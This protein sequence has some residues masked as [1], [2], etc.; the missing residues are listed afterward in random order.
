MN[1]AIRKMIISLLVLTGIIHSQSIRT[2]VDDSLALLALYNSTD[3]DNWNPPVNWMTAT[4]INWDG[5]YIEDNRVIGIGL[6]NRNLNGIIT[7]TLAILDSLKYLSLYDNPNLSGTLPPFLGSLSALIQLGIYN[8]GIGG[9]IPAEYGQLTSLRY[10]NLSNNQLSGTIPD[11]F[12]TIESL[13][14]L[15]LFDNQLSGSIPGTVSNLKNVKNLSLQGNQLS[16]IIPDN[17]TGLDSLQEL[18]L[19]DNQ[20]SGSIPNSICNLPR[21]QTLALWNNQLIGE[22]PADIGLLTNLVDLNIQNNKLT[23]AIP[24]SIGNLQNL[25]FLN[26]SANQL[27]GNLPVEFWNLSKLKHCVLCVNQLTGT[28]PEQIGNMD[29][30]QYLDLGD[31]SFSGALPAA[32]TTLSKLQSVWIGNNDLSGSLP[33]NIGDL[34]DLEELALYGNTIS[35]SIP[36]SILSCSKLRVLFLFNNQLD[37]SIPADIGS[38]VMLE[39]VALHTNKLSSSIPSSIGNCGNLRLLELWDN[40]LTGTIPSEIGS[41]TQLQNLQIGGNQISSEIPAEIYGLE[42]L[43][44]LGLGWNNLS[45]NVSSAIGNLINLEWLHLGGNQL[46]GTLPSTMGNLVNLKELHLNDNNFSGALP[47]E[48]GNL[49]NLENVS[50]VANSFSGEIPAGFSNFSYLYRLTIFDNHFTGIPNLSA[51]PLTD[52]QVQ[53]NQLTFDDIVPNAGIS[54][55]IYAPQDSVGEIKSHVIN[56]GDELTLYSAIPAVVGNN[57]NIY[58][59]FKDGSQIPNATS[60]S[61]QIVNA[62][63]NDAGVYTCWIDNSVATQLTLWQR[64]I[65]VS[66]SGTAPPVPQLTAPVNEADQVATNPTFSWRAS[67]GADDYDWQLATGRDFTS[68]EIVLSENKIEG[69]SYPVS[70]LNEDQSYYWRVRA[71]NSYGSSDWSTVWTFYTVSSLPV[72]DKTVLATPVNGAVNQ[73]LVFDLKW[74]AVT[75][76]GVY[77]L[78]VADNPSFTTLFRDVPNIDSQQY[79]LDKLTYGTTY[80]WRVQAINAAGEGPWSDTWKFTTFKLPA[81]SADNVSEITPVTVVLNGLVNAN[82]LETSVTFE[83]GQSTAYDRTVPAEQSPFTGTAETNVSAFVDNLYIGATYHYRLVAASVAGTTA[84]EDFTF[85]T[86]VYPEQYTLALAASFPARANPRDYQASD[87]RLIGLP[88]G[89]NLSVKDFI[90]GEPGQDWMVIWDNGAA[91]DY[92]VRFN[93]S[94]EFRCLPGRAFWVVAKSAVNSSRSIATATLNNEDEVEVAVHTGWNLIANPFDS[95]VSWDYVQQHNAINANE[96]LHYFD[97]SWHT[98]TMMKPYQGYYFF[99]EAGANVLRIPLHAAYARASM[100]TENPLEWQLA[101]T[102]V[103]PDL[104]ESCTSIGT[105]REAQTGRDRFDWRKPHALGTIPGIRFL[106]PEWDKKYPDFARDIRPVIEKLEKW[107]FDVTAERHETCELHF[108]GVAQIPENQ[109]VYLIDLMH[110]AFQDLRKDT[111][112]QYTAVIDCSPFALVVGDEAEVQQELSKVIPQDFALGYNFPNPFN[113]VTTIPVSMPQEAYI[114]VKIYNLLGQEIE[115]IFRGMLTT[116]KHYLTWDGS[117]YASGIYYCQLR[118]QTGQR[119]IGKMVLTK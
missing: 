112:Y 78:Q 49:I 57:Y 34:S 119:A 25:E 114:T 115:T 85:T 4:I 72:P 104:V 30:L 107:E 38:L 29:S 46:S 108:A 77:Y 53:N 65:T 61:Y 70:G 71:N 97:G 23:E 35:G 36:T 116:G 92:F 52:L 100:A 44:I 55:F 67:T 14:W 19:H 56:D 80:Y 96:I 43:T 24:T 103:T 12:F 79:H 93:D 68:S 74:N 27:S 22:I 31:N 111:V 82:G 42:N 101:F 99:N 98:S 9:E 110:A 50:L 90:S 41:L 32:F 16:G 75:N 87:Y 84:T 18:R 48:L 7:D 64:P 95:P 76:R 2:I 28:L 81:V 63:N 60:D 69:T 86:A 15:F 105:S 21:L 58:R 20:L 113:P 6:P 106:H 39:E 17:F 102:L 5:I 83:I 26:L 118:T 45:G 73:P 91:A 47:T 40:Q 59:W 1:I 51:L 109:Q 3:G 89:S 13:R 88:G 94:Q 8:T 117:R 11:A 33:V 37:G 54:G 66:V 62:N 10:C